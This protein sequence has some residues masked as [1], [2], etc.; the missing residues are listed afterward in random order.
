P[1]ARPSPSVA[2][3]ALVTGAE[4]RLPC[5]RTCRGSP[6]LAGRQTGC[7]VEGQGLPHSPLAHVVP[8]TAHACRRRDVRRT[9]CFSLLSSPPARRPRSPFPRPLPPDPLACVF[10]TFFVR[11]CEPSSRRPGLPSAR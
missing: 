4:S 8:V 7:L 5:A 2:A 11:I 10:R 3:V 9:A 6:E 1:F